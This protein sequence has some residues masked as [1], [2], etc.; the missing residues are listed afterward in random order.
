M[1]DKF[2]N[3]IVDCRRGIW[4]FGE[5]ASRKPVP[6]QRIGP[7]QGLLT[8]SKE[9]GVIFRQDRLPQKSFALIHLNFV[10][11]TFK[12]FDN[13]VSR[14]PAELGI[15]RTKRVFFFVRRATDCL[16]GS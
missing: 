9:G 15:D 10:P 12:L 2:L 11:G 7:L 6:R 1:V 3:Y 4:I 5:H 14:D 13:A 16:R 8:F